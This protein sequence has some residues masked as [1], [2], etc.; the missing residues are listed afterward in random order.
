M[1]IKGATPVEAAGVGIEVENKWL[2]AKKELALINHLIESEI[3][4]SLSLSD[5][6]L[7]TFAIFSDS[8]IFLS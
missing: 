2:D 6:L 3:F 4:S 8:I 1:G 7:A 5:M